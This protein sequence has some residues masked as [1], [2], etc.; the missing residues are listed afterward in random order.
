MLMQVKFLAMRGPADRARQGA[1]GYFVAIVD[2]DGS[3]LARQRFDSMFEFQ[4]T[5]SRT[6]LVEELQQTIPAASGVPPY[7]VYVGFGRLNEIVGIDP[8]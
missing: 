4:E 1:F 7:T 2:A 3:V 6:G 8:V 5:K